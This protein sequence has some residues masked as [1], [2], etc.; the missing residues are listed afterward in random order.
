MRCRDSERVDVASFV[1]D[2][3]HGSVKV[4]DADRDASDDPVMLPFVFDCVTVSEVVT[5]SDEESVGD[6]V[7]DLPDTD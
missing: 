4:V 6:A 5:E 7:A 1:R 3:D 2:G